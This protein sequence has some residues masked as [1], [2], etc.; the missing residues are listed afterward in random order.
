MDNTR[1]VSSTL[2]KHN[3][4]GNTLQAYSAENQKPLWL[5]KKALVQIIVLSYIYSL[6]KIVFNI[7]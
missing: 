6:N 7:T 2:P 3:D 4:Y 5:Y 1:V